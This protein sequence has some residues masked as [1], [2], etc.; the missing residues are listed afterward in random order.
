MAENVTNARIV[1]GRVE[2]LPPLTIVDSPASP[3]PQTPAD[4]DT[5]DEYV[6]YCPYPAYPE[7]PSA[8]ASLPEQS[9]LPKASGS[10][11]G[12]RSP[13]PPTATW[14][15][16]SSSGD[17]D[18]GR[19]VPFSPTLPHKMVLFLLFYYIYVCMIIRTTPHGEEN[20]GIN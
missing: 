6:D 18:G 13:T 12:P 9:A 2:S 4:D 1:R 19:W 3:D 5:D 8:T 16:S 10:M 11:T 20:I 14:S 17:G 7:T 15:W